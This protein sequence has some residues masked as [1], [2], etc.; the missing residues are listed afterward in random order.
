MY[1][2][3]YPFIFTILFQTTDIESILA[4]EKKGPSDFGLSM[5]LGEQNYSI[6]PRCFPK[7]LQILSFSAKVM[8]SKSLPVVENLFRAQLAWAFKN[9]R[10]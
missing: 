5:T 4:L 9:G 6:L 3:N 10:F 2:S 7:V 8:G 1:V